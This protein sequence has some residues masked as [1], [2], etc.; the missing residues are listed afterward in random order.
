[1]AR[2]MLETSVNRFRNRNGYKL[3]FLRIE[4]A[5]VLRTS[6]ASCPSRD[7]KRADASPE[8]GPELL[9]N[10]LPRS[11]KTGYHEAGGE[12]D[13]ICVVIGPDDMHIHGVG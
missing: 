13:V 11:R 1:M 2:E 4:S 10:E 7:R 3:G 8:F 12:L 6:Y 9:S 5:F